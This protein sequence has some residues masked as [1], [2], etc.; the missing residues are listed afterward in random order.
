VQQIL[1]L[2]GTPKDKLESESAAVLDIETAS[3]AA[4]SRW[5]IS[6][7]RSTTTRRSR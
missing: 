7:T 2:T 6:T 5:A 3:R 4:G 1:A